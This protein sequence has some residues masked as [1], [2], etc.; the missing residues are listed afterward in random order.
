MKR[1]QITEKDETRKIIRMFAVKKLNNIEEDK[2]NKV[3]VLSC[4]ILVAIPDKPGSKKFKTYLVLLDSGATSYLMDKNITRIHG[5][6]E[7][8]TP[9]KEK[10]LTQYGVFKTKAKVTLEQMKL[11]QSATKRT[12]PT[13]MNLFKKAKE[14]PYDFILGGKFLQDIKLDIKNS[15]RT[16]AWNESEIPMVPRRLWELL[17]N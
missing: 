16:F 17:E 13:E 9:I 14:D 8:V 1:L 7:N 3:K 10:W 2:E 15:T 4:E 12:V 5:L 6:D 11:P